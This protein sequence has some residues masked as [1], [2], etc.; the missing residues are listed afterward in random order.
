MLINSPNISGS[1][2]VTGNATISGSLNVAGGINATITGSATSASYVE[3]SNVANK[4]TLVSGSSQISFNGIVDKPTLVSGSSQV[5]YS[6][7]SG[8][9]S[10]I[11][12]SSAQVGGY[13]I[14]ATTGSNTFVG[15]QTITGSI[16]GTGS[17]TID[18]CITATGQ[19]VAQTINVQQVTSSIVYSSGS[20]IFGTDISNTQQFTGS[21]LITGSLCVAGAGTFSSTVT[22]TG[23]TFIN[24]SNQNTLGS[25]ALS[26]L[27]YSS[28]NSSANQNVTLGL[29]LNDAVNNNIAYQ[30]NLGVGGNASG[31]NLSLT[32]KRNN[33][34][35]LTILGINGTTGN[36]GIGTAC[37]SERLDVVGGGLASGNG[38]IKTG[39]TYSSFGLVGTFSNHDLGV[40]TNSAQRMLIS[41]TGIACFACQVCSP[42]FVGPLTGNVNGY[43]I[44]AQTSCLL[45]GASADVTVYFTSSV[46]ITYGVN[47]YSIASYLDD[48]SAEF[49]SVRA[50]IPYNYY[51]STTSTVNLASYIDG[52][53]CHSALVVAVCKL[54]NSNTNCIAVRFAKSSGNV[55]GYRIVVTSNGITQG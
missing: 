31:Q 50:L 13:G 36:V 33:T 2:T 25:G 26:L 11:V 27:N 51:A 17:L 55:S 15:S 1:L 29:G 23:G 39:I 16:F 20:N 32:S 24:G 42:R 7:L 8:I 37:P 40:I 9:P 28:Y 41:S 47:D 30:Y 48:N 3:Y 49:S 19:I 52:I 21:M 43:P 4:P 6:G 12:S 38:T 34:T 46:A 10:G 45:G 22:A 53:H 54:V 14:F 35:D 18:G 44:I 5:T